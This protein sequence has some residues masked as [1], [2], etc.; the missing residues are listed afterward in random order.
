M[1]VEV[2]NK[3]LPIR[4]GRNRVRVPGAEPVAGLGA[5]QNRVRDTTSAH[6]PR[7]VG[8][9]GRDVYGAVGELQCVR[10]VCHASS[11]TDETPRKSG[12]A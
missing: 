8:D 7:L 5:A 12:V 2:A 11:L 1:S 10:G 6:E 9:L 4:A 3:R